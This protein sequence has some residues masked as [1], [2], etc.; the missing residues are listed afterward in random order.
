MNEESFPSYPDYTEKTHNGRRIFFILAGFM[1][2]VLIVVAGLYVL[3]AMHK[4]SAPE[5]PVPTAKPKPSATPLPTAS[6]SAVMSGSLTASISP[7]LGLSKIDTTTK[8]NRAE[9]SIA[10]LNGSGEKG[11]AS[12]VADYL[13]GL[14]YKIVSVGNADVYTYKN[15]TVQLKKT[16]SNFATLLKKDLQDNPALASVSASIS[17]DISND[18]EV[19][20]GK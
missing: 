16:K 8:L 3:G 4:N 6:V 13:K 5:A 1:V 17:D 12:Q 19:I 9:L 7:T 15:I 11:A 14:G 20:V 2:L 10:V 18:A